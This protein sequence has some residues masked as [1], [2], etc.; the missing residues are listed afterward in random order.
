MPGEQGSSN[1]CCE[2]EFDTSHVNRI[3]SNCSTPKF[4][5]VCYPLFRSSLSCRPA[6]GR[7]RCR[8]AGCKHVRQ[9]AHPRFQHQRHQLRD[10]RS[11]ARESTEPYRL[12][13]P[14]YHRAVSSCYIKICVHHCKY[15]GLPTSSPL[16]DHTRALNEAADLIDWFTYDV[17]VTN[18]LYARTASFC[19]GTSAQFD[20]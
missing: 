5:L 2:D 7:G 14:T 3:F 17:S 10:Q 8:G 19:T 20:T 9:P 18:R 13:T 1:S 15:L 11:H 12:K 4:L 16:Q 6:R